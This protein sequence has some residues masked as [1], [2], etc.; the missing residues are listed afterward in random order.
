MKSWVK[1]VGLLLVVLLYSIVLGQRYA[2]AAEPALAEEEEA[3][4]FGKAVP[5]KSPLCFSIIAAAEVATAGAKEGLAE[6]WHLLQYHAQVNACVDPEG[7]KVTFTHR[8]LRAVGKNGV[9]RVYYGTYTSEEDGV[10]IPVYVLP[11]IPPWWARCPATLPKGNF[12]V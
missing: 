10:T 8:V 7:K 1:P 12:C 3:F 9:S 6:A 2:H 4:P 11:D 5:V